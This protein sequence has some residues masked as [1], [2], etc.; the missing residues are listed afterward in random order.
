[1][2][3]DLWK[4]AMLCAQAHRICWRVLG[5]RGI[6]CIERCEF[7]IL[8]ADFAGLGGLTDLVDLQAD[9]AGGSKGLVVCVG[10]VG[11]WD[12]VE[13][14]LDAAALGDDG[15]VV[16]LAKL[17]RLA[18]GFVFGEVLEP[19]RLP[20]GAT[21]LEVDAGGPFAV[22]AGVDLTLVAVDRSPSPS[23]RTWLRSWIPELKSRS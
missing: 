23:G 11:G 18:G 12:V 19:D 14:G 1:M 8:E 9:E 22:R 3:S 15:D 4:R 7:E 2:V 21:S 17:E 13:P 20:F 16:P 5:G 10:V 6:G